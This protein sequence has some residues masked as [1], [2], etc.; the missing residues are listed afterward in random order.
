MKKRHIQLLV[1]IILSVIFL[2]LAFRRVD[3]ARLWET[4]RSINFWWFIPF[5]IVTLISMYFRAIRWHFLFLPRYRIKTTRLFPPLMVGFAFNGILPARAGEFARAYLGA[6]REKLD[7]STMF[8]TVVVER[9][10]DGLTIIILFTLGLLFLPSF[11]P[12]VSE[13]WNAQTSMKGSTL[14]IILSAVVAVLFI[15]LALFMKYSIAYR[16][17]TGTPAL[18]D[19]RCTFLGKTTRVLGIERNYTLFV[20]FSFIGMIIS[21]IAL[22]LLIGGVL[23]PKDETLVWGKVYQINSETLQN[24][25][26]RTGIVL[27][28]LVIVLILLLINRTREIFQTILMRMP[29]IPMKLKEIASHLLEKFAEGLGA[30]QSG[31]ALVMI[32]INSFAVWILV[33]VSLQVMSLGFEQVTLNFWHA[34]F[35][36]V[37]ICITIS[38]PAAPGYWGLYEFGAIIAMGL[39]PIRQPREVALSFSLIIHAGQMFPIIAIGLYFAIR[40]HVS[41]QAMTEKMEHEGEGT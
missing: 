8:A 30:L 28:G 12:G 25:S 24:I 15:V 26:R 16:K 4:L 10:F 36:V 23:I 29:I 2:Y 35:I 22:G 7:F 11:D 40:E 17:R 27:V 14:I 21:I 13:Q 6:R 37:I 39:L 32:I 9:I 19:I 31:K 20:L 34:I 5:V 38:I 18:E 1:G 3:F 41:Y 33:G